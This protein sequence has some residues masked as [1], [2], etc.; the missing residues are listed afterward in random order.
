M[1]LNLIVV[2][3]GSAFLIAV[4]HRLLPCVSAA[5]MAKALP[6]PGIPAASVGETLSF[7]AVPRGSL[8][9]SSPTRAP[10][11]ELQS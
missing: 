6:L 5:S 3:M 9:R 7:L 8:W 1:V 11:P 4:R 10:S 2:G